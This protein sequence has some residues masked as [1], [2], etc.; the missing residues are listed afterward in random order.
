[1]Q[2][3]FSTGC[4]R[5]PLRGVLYTEGVVHAL[6]EQC[7]GTG[8]QRRSWALLGRSISYHVMRK[9]MQSGKRTIQVSFENDGAWC[10]IHH[11]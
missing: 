5:P 8:I 4:V 2:T 7:I 6:L 11:Q 1:V 10:M 9:A 3:A